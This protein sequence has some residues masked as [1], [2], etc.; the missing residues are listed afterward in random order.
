MHIQV[1]SAKDGRHE[2]ITLTDP[3]TIL[4]GEKMDRLICG[5]IEHWFT[6]DGTYDGWGM[7]L[8]G[9]NLTPDEARALIDNVE[10]SRVFP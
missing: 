7:N 9:M 3:V 8:E 5:N 10:K 4:R 6:K 1:V 2:L